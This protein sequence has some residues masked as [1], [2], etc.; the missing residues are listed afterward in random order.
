[1]ISDGIL[2]L[3][4]LCVWKP[5]VMILIYIELCL[6]MAI[7]FLTTLIME[8]SESLSPIT[9]IIGATLMLPNSFFLT[10][11][12]AYMYIRKLLFFGPSY[13]SNYKHMWKCLMCIASAS[14]L[15][16]FISGLPT[17]KLVRKHNLLEE[18]SVVYRFFKYI[19]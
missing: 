7:L 2:L 14:L 8:I 16:R 11:V 19:I 3:L 13:M 17:P 1:M 10:N 5:L 18:V 4:V 15:Y 6:K 12:T 9:M